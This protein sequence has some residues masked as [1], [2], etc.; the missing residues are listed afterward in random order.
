LQNDVTVPPSFLIG[1]SGIL[2]IGAILMLESDPEKHKARIVQL[3]DR[4]SINQLE[5]C[6]DPDGAED[7]I[8]YGNAGYLYSVLLL[9]N[10]LKEDLCQG[11]FMDQVK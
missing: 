9:K 4:L 11:L 1:L 2:T 5:F 3:V 10:Y 6:F 8:L 7:E